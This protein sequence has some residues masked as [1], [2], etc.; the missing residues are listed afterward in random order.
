MP[1]GD[2][3]AVLAPKPTLL[4]ATPTP[5]TTSATF[6]PVECPFWTA[7]HPAITCGYLA[8]PE[9]RASDGSRQ[10]RLFVAIAHTTGDN[11]AADPLV[12]LH[13]G[14]GASAASA[15]SYL[16]DSLQDVL[17]S[18]DLIVFDQ[19]GSGLSE[20][21]LDCVEWPGIFY[22]RYD[23]ILPPE[24]WRALTE[25]AHLACYQRLAAGGIDLSAYHS[26]ASAADVNDLRLALGYAQVNLYGISYGTRLALT[27]MRDY[28]HAVRSAILDSTLPLEVDLYASLAAHTARSL[29]RLFAQ[30][31][32]DSSCSA[33][34]PDLERRFY[35]LT[36]RLDAE[37]LAL[38]LLNASDGQL[39]EVL[40]HGDM[41]ITAA[42][43]ALYDTA[44]IPHLPRYFGEL[45][46][47]IITN[48]PELIAPVAFQYGGVS[49]GAST[50]V[51]CNEELA[52]SSMMPLTDTLHPR[53]QQYV[54]RGRAVQVNECGLWQLPGGLAV[55]N[56]PVR[57]AIPTL[58][59][60]GA[61]DP[62][63]PPA[64]G[65]QVAATLDNA[66]FYEFPGVGHGVLR[67]SDCGRELAAAF[68]MAPAEPA[69]PVC[70]PQLQDL[71]FI[72]R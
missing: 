9:N 61:Y 48:W 55:E 47:G 44:R 66:F 67:G 35:A 19:R 21:S 5:E 30:C 41:F 60:A 69:L 50:A 7:A 26:A 63:T 28:P 32:G 25:Q 4:P 45:E 49:E 36:D 33:A 12:Y 43:L 64:W 24:A 22:S 18:R 2:P 57:S 20:P 11:R 52:F 42:R 65:Q 68:V 53:L 8:V 6:T 23:E 39:Y 46:R 29:D 34:F 27:L 14:P 17:S 3:A 15:V 38:Q 1:A 31:A 58:V 13:G 59:L 16:A 56:E 70:L 72:I 71:G 37:P 62:I 40:V 54:A 10:I 51:M